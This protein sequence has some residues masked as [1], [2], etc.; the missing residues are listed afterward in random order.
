MRR[1][2][3]ERR[4]SVSLEAGDNPDSKQRLAK[5][6]DLIL[7]ASATHIDKEADYLL[8]SDS[9]TTKSD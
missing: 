5:A 4:M 6:L 3:I 1:K 9:A 8:S 2:K 7:R